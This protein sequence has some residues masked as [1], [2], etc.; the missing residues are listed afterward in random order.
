MF[1][2]IRTEKMGGG[3][4][5]AASLDLNPVIVA[6]HNDLDILVVQIQVEN[7][8]IR[9]INSHGPQEDDEIS[10]IKHF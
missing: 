1:E 9:V 10:K 5:T 2:T 3:L 8:N 4:L 7:I 6:S